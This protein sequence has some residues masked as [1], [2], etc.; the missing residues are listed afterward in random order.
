[1]LD[2]DS[3]QIEA[4][5]RFGWRAFYGDATRLDLLRVAGAAQARVLVVAI[6]DVAQIGARLQARIWLEHAEGETPLDVTKIA[7]SSSTFPATTLM[8]QSKFVEQ[9]FDEAC[10]DFARQVQDE[11][12]KKLDR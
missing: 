5:R 2:H 9:L 7:N 12:D 6:D 3:E 10:S 8:S 1:M 11:V 4:V